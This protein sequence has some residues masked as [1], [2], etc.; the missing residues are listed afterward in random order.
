MK[1]AI[2]ERTSFLYKMMLTEQG[3]GLKIEE[4]AIIDEFQN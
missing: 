2:L 1:I 4:E 3:N